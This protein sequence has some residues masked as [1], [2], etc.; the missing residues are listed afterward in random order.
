MKTFIAAIFILALTGCAQT[1]MG[2]LNAL[3]NQYNTKCNTTTLSG[4]TRTS[5][6]EV[7]TKP[8]GDVKVNKVY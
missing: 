1:P 5:M 4:G 7:C 8:S 3:N 2:R 6:Y